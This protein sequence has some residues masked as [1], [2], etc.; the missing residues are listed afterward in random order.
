MFE[1]IKKY[2]QDSFILVF[3][4]TFATTIIMLEIVLGRGKT[5]PYVRD[6][7]IYLGSCFPVGALISTA[8]CLISLVNQH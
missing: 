1:K 8:T 6:D 4:F 5:L 3:T 7:H 2:V